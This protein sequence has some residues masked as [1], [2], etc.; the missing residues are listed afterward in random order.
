MSDTENIRDDV[1]PWYRRSDA[2]DWFAEGGEDPQ[3]GW[4]RRVTFATMPSGRTIAFRPNELLCSDNWAAQAAQFLRDMHGNDDIKVDEGKPIGKRY[5]RLLC[6]P[7]PI[8][9]IEDLR[10]HLG[11]VAQPNHVFFMHCGSYCPPHPAWRFAAG[12][13]YAGGGRRR[14]NPVEMNPVEMNPVEMNPVEMNPVEMNPVEMNPVEMNPV[15]MN[16]NHPWRTM[17]VKRSSA[18][19]SRPPKPPRVELAVVEATP[20]R[21]FVLDTGLAVNVEG[22]APQALAELAWITGDRVDV[23]DSD[24]DYLLD[25]TAG[26]GTF[27]AGVIQNVAPGVPIEVQRVAS[28]YGDISEST[29]AAAIEGIAASAD[30]GTILSLSFGGYAY[31]DQAA[32]LAGAIRVF[33][34]TMG[35]V[36][37]SAGNDATCCPTYPAALPGVISV[38]ALGPSGPARFTNYGPWVRA[39]APGVDLE[40]MFFQYAVSDDPSHPDGPAPDSDDPDDFIGTAYWSGT[41]FAGPVV[42]GALARRMA[43]DGITAAEAVKRVIDAPELFRFPDLGTVVNVI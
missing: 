3:Y 33:Q 1:T 14:L 36:V 41:S 40:N 38:G 18:R 43:C 2:E 17:G 31:D 6:V 4:S 27:I 25:V 11:V 8:R 34:D 21:V 28:I 23:P 32:I 13:G 15:E 24:N 7:D 16:P 19:P 37:A 39:C 12:Y 20:P 42:V 10:V 26:H 29:A 35:I 30:Q 5:R 22:T 9:A